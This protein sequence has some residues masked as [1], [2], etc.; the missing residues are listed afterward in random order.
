AQRFNHVYGKEYFPL[1]DV[2]IDEQ[3]ATLAGLDGRKMSKSYRVLA[4][5]RGNRGD[6]N[7]ETAFAS[8][9]THSTTY[10][11][12]NV[13]VSDEAAVSAAI[14]QAHDFLGGLN[15][16]MNCAGILGAGRV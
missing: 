8:A 9:G 7:W 10:Q 6:W 5:A 1:P 4:G 16:A 15:V 13:N 12:I 14:D 3:V 11:T 2:V